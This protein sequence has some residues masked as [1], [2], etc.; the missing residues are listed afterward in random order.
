[1]T[2]PSRRSIELG[3]PST[4]PC[5][6][7]R[8]AMPSPGCSR[9]GPSLISCRC[10]PVLGFLS[11]SA[12]MTCPHCQYAI[13]VSAKAL[14]R[15]E[16]KEAA[17][18]HAGMMANGGGAA[19]AGYDGY[20]HPQAGQHMRQQYQQ[21]GGAGGGGDEPESP[22]RPRQKRK[23]QSTKKG[24]MTAT[25]EELAELDEGLSDEE[26]TSWRKSSNQRRA[27]EAYACAC[28]SGRTHT[29]RAPAAVRTGL[30]AA[31]VAQPRARCCFFPL[32]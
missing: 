4:A 12:S 27:G 26:Q 30:T 21:G 28:V 13:P 3:S 19:A 5:V 29:R 7:A 31:P 6:R 24:M 25:E 32:S 11:L 2:L 10:L 23:R 9:Q 22:E 8:H 15:R 1:M 17:V 20:N 16:M 14:A 18:H